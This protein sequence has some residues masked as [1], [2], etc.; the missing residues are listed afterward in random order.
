MK[1]QRIIIYLIIIIIG[2][3]QSLSLTAKDLFDTDAKK[4]EQ[5]RIFNDV[6]DNLRRLAE[7]SNTT[8]DEVIFNKD[9]GLL[10]GTYDAIVDNDHQLFGTIY[11]EIL[12]SKTPERQEKI[13]LSIR[14][15]LSAIQKQGTN[16]KLEL[17]LTNLLSIVRQARGTTGYF[18]DFI[19]L[20]RTEKIFWLGV[21]GVATYAGYKFLSKPKIVRRKQ[22]KK[23]VHSHY[24]K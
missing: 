23:K 17:F 8:S 4:R 1:S 5:A 24:G 3:L 11:E 6:L 16:K 9:N 7:I 15:K 10:A 18:Y 13:E 2:G 21:A 12:S 22:H 20:P 19:A 14:Q